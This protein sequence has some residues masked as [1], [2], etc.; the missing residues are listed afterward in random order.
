M[1]S[2][3]GF[4]RGTATAG[5]AQIV[6][7][8]KSVNHRFL[9]IRTRL[10]GELGGVEI[11]LEKQ[12]RKRLERGYC[13]VHVSVEQNEVS[14]YTINTAK[15]SRYIDM[16]RETAQTRALPAEYL[17]LILS[18]APD[19]YE[20]NLF[21]ADDDMQDACLRATRQAIDKLLEMRT[22]E[23]ANMETDLQERLQQIRKM[24]DDIDALSSNFER[25]IFEKY[26]QKIADILAEHHTP[27]V[28]RVETEAA[29]IAEKADVTEELTRLRSHTEQMRATFRSDGAIGRRLDFLVQE[30]GRE[31]NTIASKSA[32]ADV[33]HIIVDIKG[34]LEKIRE[35]VQN[36]E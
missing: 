35:L 36:V 9:E 29:I 31:A 8:L 25:S 3:T 22:V 5:N 4:G 20:S 1:R 32:L 14:A 19:L 24:V 26:R 11:A 10:P 16:I 30:M 6:V 23:G 21:A 27:D 7:E 28:K 33:T 12:I 2:M 34:E 18:N 17:M 13:N 15:L